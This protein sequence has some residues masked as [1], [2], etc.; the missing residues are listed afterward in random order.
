MA[1]EDEA[2]FAAVAKKEGKAWYVVVI[3]DTWYGECSVPRALSGHACHHRL[4]R[5]PHC[6][7]LCI[8]P[9][10]FWRHQ[11]PVDALLPIM[12]PSSGSPLTPSSC[13]P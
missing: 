1:A 6:L 10:T 3:N 11:P 12:V 7:S 13:P 9:Q 4:S 5:P 2:R 8:C